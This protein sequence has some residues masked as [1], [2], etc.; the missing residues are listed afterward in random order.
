MFRPLGPLACLI[1]LSLLMAAACSDDTTPAPD[2]AVQDDIGVD[3][4]VQDDSTVDS[5]PPADT[6]V[7]A[8]LTDAAQPD[9]AL[10]DAP[11]LDKA[12]PDKALPDKALLDK[13]LPDKALPDKGTLPLDLGPGG[14]N[15]NADCTSTQYCDMPLGCTP[16][17]VCKA[18]P[19]ICTGLYDP[20]C[21]CNYTSYGNTC[22][23]ASAGTSVRSKGSC[24]AKTCIQIR[25][26][27]AAAIKAAKTCSPPLTVV[28]C[29][30]VVTK[31]LAC[32]CKTAVNKLNAKDYANI[33]A[34][35]ALWVKLSCSLQAWN[36][37]KMPCKS[38][39]SGK[40]DSTT[41]ACIDVP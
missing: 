10:P 9:A 33:V 12:L 13:A 30:T 4:A 41:S 5:A 16:P 38:V 36:C 35:D 3:I 28:Q 15:S 21:G 18:R 1:A 31:D 7:D 37:P 14:C 25:T 11:L 40:C 20:V 39:S 24:P 23:A 19:M 6:A 22:N 2:T 34:L 27:Y 8:P 32:G 17:G 29:A 26:D